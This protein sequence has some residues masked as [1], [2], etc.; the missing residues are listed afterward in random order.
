MKIGTPTGFPLSACRVV[1]TL[2]EA[3]SE[4]S[5]E[6]FRRIGHVGL[7]DAVVGMQHAGLQSDITAASVGGFVLQGRRQGMGRGRILFATGRAVVAS[8]F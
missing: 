6:R 3:S 4:R 2:S 7:L 8:C 5:S 1:A